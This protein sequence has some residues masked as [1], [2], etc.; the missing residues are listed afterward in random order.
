MSIENISSGIHQMLQGK[1]LDEDQFEKM[2]QRAC[3]CLSNFEHYAEEQVSDIVTALN[4]ALNSQFD[5]LV[6]RYK[7]LSHIIKTLEN[8]YLPNNRLLELLQILEKVAKKERLRWELS[9]FTE[10]II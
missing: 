4:V 6:A 8:Y 2:V 5:Y 1:Y 7:S 3:I 10:D 9:K